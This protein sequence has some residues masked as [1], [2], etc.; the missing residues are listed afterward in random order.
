MRPIGIDAVQGSTG[1]DA[2]PYRGTRQLSAAIYH[3]FLPAIIFSALLVSIPP[4]DRKMPKVSVTWTAAQE[5][6]LVAHLHEYKLAKGAERGPLI[7]AALVDVENLPLGLLQG[8]TEEERTQ[9][10]KCNVQVMLFIGAAG[11][12]EM[13]G[14]QCKDDG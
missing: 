9:V 14:S 8:K 1:L 10:C 5:K 3:L 6:A 7:Q 2:S 11:S 12:S 4:S 13:V